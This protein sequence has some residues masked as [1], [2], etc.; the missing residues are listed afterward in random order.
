MMISVA[1]KRNLCTAYVLTIH[2]LLS[3][4]HDSQCGFLSVARAA[5]IPLKNV[6]RQR[7]GQSFAAQ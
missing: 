7:E 4:A 1:Y 3:T 6:S 2:T 5:H